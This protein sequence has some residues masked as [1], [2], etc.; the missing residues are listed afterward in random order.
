LRFPSGSPHDFAKSWT[1]RGSLG[2]YG[3]GRGGGRLTTESGL[4]PNLSKLRRDG[5]FQPGCSQSGSLIWTNTTRDA[6]KRVICDD[7]QIET[8]KPFDLCRNAAYPRPTKPSS[9]I[10]Q[11]DGSGTAVTEKAFPSIELSADPAAPAKSL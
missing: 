5:L 11:V 8:A 3:S 6:G 7:S 1:L 9:I 4:T 10:A 2:G